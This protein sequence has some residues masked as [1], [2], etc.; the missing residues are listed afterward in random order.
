[1]ERN[2][3]QWEIDSSSQSGDEDYNPLQNSRLKPGPS[4]Y[5]PLSKENSMEPENHID[6]RVGMLP[7]TVNLH[8]S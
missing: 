2:W 6:G 3:E 5:R 8:T 7:Y 4:N 1:M